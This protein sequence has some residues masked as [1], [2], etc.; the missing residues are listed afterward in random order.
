MKD[1]V[2]V[3][4][5]VTAHAGKDSLLREALLALTTIAKTE[6]GFIQYDLHESADRPGHFVFYEIWEDEASLDL[7]SNS[8]AIKAHVAKA[9]SWT[10]SV[11][12]EKYRRIS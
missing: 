10:K 7:H 6:R 2:V 12:I 4:S 11:S 8:D 3:V 5:N 1:K 9:G